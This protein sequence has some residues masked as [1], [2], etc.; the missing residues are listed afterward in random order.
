ALEE[1]FVGKLD[2]Q[3]DALARHY[4]RSGNAPK[5][6]E[7]LRGAADQ[8]LTR[9]AYKE[10]LGY[11]NEALRLLAELPD[12][13]ERDRDEIAI[14]RCRG[15]L[16][17]ATHG[18]ASPDIAQCLNRALALC[19]RMGEGP[20][21]FSVIFGLWN[22]NFARNRLHDAMRLAEKLLRLSQLMDTELA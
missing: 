14:Q 6:V 18:F 22:L 3:V 13:L 9:S 15:W 12:S 7:F 1:L 16:L 20:E 5:A 11:V 4:S 19:Q 21:L 10:G 17:M 8:A 2:E